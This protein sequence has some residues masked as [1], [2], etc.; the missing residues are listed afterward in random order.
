MGGCTH[1]TLARQ[2][3]RAE[4]PGPPTMRIFVWTGDRRLPLSLEGALD[5]GG[6]SGT[7]EWMFRVQVIA[8][9]ARGD[10]G[11]LI[12]PPSVVSA[13]SPQTGVPPCG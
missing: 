12:Y 1:E 11:K 10:E 3:C 8:T 13:P 2:R 6:Q 4:Q 7:K 9:S 5:G